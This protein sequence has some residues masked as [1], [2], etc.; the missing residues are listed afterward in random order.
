ESLRRAVAEVQPDELYHLA[1]PT[2]VPASWEDPAA[3]FA[4]IAGASAVLLGAAGDARVVVAASSEVFGD[5]RESPQGEGSPMRPRSPYGVAK[6]AVLHLVRLHR[7]RGVHASAAIT[8][9]H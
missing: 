6:L 8:F 4:Q 3:T 2:F 7:E 1:A 5:S 9:N